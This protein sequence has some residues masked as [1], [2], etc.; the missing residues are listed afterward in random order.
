[1]S[2][3]RAVC[4]PLNHYLTETSQ[5]TI[6]QLERKALF[7]NIVEKVAWVAFIAI[8]A[9]VLTTYYCG[10]VLTGG[11]AA[12]MVGLILTTPFIMA[13]LPKFRNDINRCN[14]AIETEQKVVAEQAK[15]SHW[16]T[17]EVKE[18]LQTQE[19]NSEEI[20]LDALKQISPDEPLVAL[21]PLIARF[22]Y[23][24]NG[25]IRIYD[26]AT[27][28]LNTKTVEKAL[29]PKDPK[30]S[31]KLLTQI[32]IRRHTRQIEWQKIEFSAIPI[33]FEAA[34]ILQ[35]MKDPRH[36][37]N[38]ESIGV[39]TPKPYD[40]RMFDSKY[41]DKDE[42]FVFNDSKRAPITFTEIETVKL[43]PVNL[44]QRLYG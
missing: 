9:A 22:N 16:K 21:L 2:V 13:F 19:L 36:N 8:M 44:R 18:F 25:A 24:K 27:K 32:T 15:I 30:Y 33:A 23:L 1:M 26:E 4:P 34:E 35:I 12:L 20:L 10:Y 42:Y 31:D 17:A 14:A 6:S 28:V 5:K 11:T 38:L 43:D 41:E 29:D 37:G 7:L 39:R 40:G 3:T